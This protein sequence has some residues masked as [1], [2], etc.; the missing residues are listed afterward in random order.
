MSTEVP[1]NGAGGR[2]QRWPAGL[3]RF[4]RR[5]HE[6]VPAPWTAFVLAGGGSRGAV[7]VGMLAELVARGI[8]AD[9]VY[10]ASV[11]A[12]NGAAYCG[13]PTSEGV[14]RLETV[15]RGLTGADVFPRGR[16]HGPWT[17]LQHRPSVHANGGLRRIVEEGVSFERLEDAVIPLEIV[18]TSLTDGQERWITKGPVVEAVMASAAIPA[19]FPPVV[20]EG[21]VLVDGG[22]V[23]NV[24]ISRPVAA[25]AGRVYV[26][27]CGPLH[28]RPRAPQR[29][30][31]AVLTAF[32]VAI[33]ARFARELA[34]LPPGV[35]VV[36]FSGGG[37][38]SADYRDFSASG[39]LIDA[40]RAEV[41]SVLDRYRGTAH[42]LQPEGRARGDQT[43]AAPPGPAG[44]A[45]TEHQGATPQ[46]P[47]VEAS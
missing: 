12:V 27:L 18:T 28:F 5:R 15:W 39:E 4:R 14:K 16:V 31:E 6:A 22:V 7:Q 3:S 45:P 35:E 13:D 29:P 20:I 47:E 11:G 9:R 21:D 23:D 8:R 2:R 40:G 10:G 34:Q 36:V 17:F 30:V 37:D 32:F 25:G 41:A 1:D 19:I 38:P 24:P 43:R 42:D 33:H 46:G 26:L 44:P